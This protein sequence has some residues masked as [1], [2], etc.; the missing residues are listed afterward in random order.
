MVAEGEDYYHFYT[1]PTTW[2]NR[3]YDAKK[4]NGTDEPDKG[5]EYRQKMKYLLS[6]LDSDIPEIRYANTIYSDETCNTVYWNID[7]DKQNI[8][9]IPDIVYTKNP[10]TGLGEAHKVVGIGKGTYLGANG[11]TN[12]KWR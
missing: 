7:T 3:Y 10:D 2:N 12:G 5:L 1:E 8:K 9:T 6:N 4:Y 11:V